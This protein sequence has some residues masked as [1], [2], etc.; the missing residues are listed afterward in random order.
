M[1]GE[2]IKRYGLTA[3]LGSGL[4]LLLMPAGVWARP[5]LEV[6]MTLG[7]SVNP[8]YWYV[9][10][11]SSAA[12][13]GPRAN[14]TDPNVDIVGDEEAF[15]SDWD[16]LI[17]VKPLNDESVFQA[18]LEEE[19]STEQDFLTGFN[20]VRLRE[21][22]RPQDTIELVIDLEELA[23]LNPE[24]E[25]IHVSLMTIESPF[26]LDPEETGLALDAVAGDRPHFYELSLSD[27]KRVQVIDPQRQETLRRSRQMI[28]EERV[29]VIDSIEASSLAVLAAN[30]LTFDLELVER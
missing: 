21:T 1:I 28:S 16:Y 6:S 27:I 29:S 7:L 19:G 10:A 25:D 11:L 20:E 3:C 22:S 17:R 12:R 26:V 15:V 2:R 9:V 18:T 23:R 8:D 4:S 24:E 14:L 13:S 5:T 30:I